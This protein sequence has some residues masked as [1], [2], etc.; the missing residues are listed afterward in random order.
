MLFFEENRPFGVVPACNA[1][2]QEKKKHGSQ[3]TLLHS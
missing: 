1:G 2:I 3:W